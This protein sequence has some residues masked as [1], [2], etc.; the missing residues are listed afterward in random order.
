MFFIFMR[1]IYQTMNLSKEQIN[2]IYSLNKDKVW[3]HNTSKAKNIILK[4]L[5][6]RGLV[7]SKLYANEYHWEITYKGKEILNQH[8]TH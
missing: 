5:Y 2:V 4:S 3:L 8:L 1:L 6:V 7:S